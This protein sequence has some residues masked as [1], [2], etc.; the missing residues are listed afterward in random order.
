MTRWLASLRSELA[1]YHQFEKKAGYTEEITPCME[2][3]GVGGMGFHYGD[4]MLIDG[5]VE[6]LKPELLLYAP[7]KNGRMRLVAVEYIV[8]FTAWTDATPPSLY[9]LEFSPNQTFQ[10]WALHAWVWRNNPRG[11]FADLCG[12]GTQKQLLQWRQDGRKRVFV[13]EFRRTWHHIVLMAQPDM[14]PAVMGR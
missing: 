5:K 1:G 11:M 6:A 13:G 2:Q 7:E 4:P 3:P 9:G 10:V 8:P 14:R 12:P